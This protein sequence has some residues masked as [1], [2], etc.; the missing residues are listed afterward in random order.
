M[1]VVCVRV[2]L[3]SCRESVRSLQGRL[4]PLTDLSHRLPDAPPKNGRPHRPG[5]GA[6][7][8]RDRSQRWLPAAA[9]PAQPAAGRRGEVLEQVRPAGQQVDWRREEKLNCTSGSLT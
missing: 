5:H 3:R 7:E 6:T 1:Y 9:V 4:Q 8:K 2:C